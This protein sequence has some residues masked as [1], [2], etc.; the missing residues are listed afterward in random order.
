M[1]TDLYA[2]LAKK[3]GI[4]FEEA[5]K[6]PEVEFNNFVESTLDSPEKLISFMKKFD[7]KIDSLHTLHF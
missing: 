5:T 7:N 6:L 2:Q 3:K 1:I 4:S